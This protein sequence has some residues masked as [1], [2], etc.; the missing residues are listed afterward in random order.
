MLL[1]QIKFVSLN[2]FGV[3]SS[4]DNSQHCISNHLMELHNA[5][6]VVKSTYLFFTVIPPPARHMAAIKISHFI[7]FIE[8]FKHKHI[9]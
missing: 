5:D 4:V 7:A 6:Q 9:P 1:K 2:T 3:E 8:S